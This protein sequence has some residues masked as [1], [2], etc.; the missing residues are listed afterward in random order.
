MSSSQSQP[1]TELQKIYSETEQRIFIQSISTTP[2]IHKEF[3]KTSGYFSRFIYNPVNASKFTGLSEILENLQNPSEMSEEAVLNLKYFLG[4]KKFNHKTPKANK[5]EL[6]QLEALSKVVYSKGFKLYNKVRPVHIKKTLLHIIRL[7]NNFKDIESETRI[8]ACILQ[9][10]SVSKDSNMGEFIKSLIDCTS[11]QYVVGSYSRVYKLTEI[12]SELWNATR[13]SAREFCETLELVPPMI[14]SKDVL[15]VN[16]SILELISRIIPLHKIPLMSRN[17]KNLEIVYIDNS[18]KTTAFNREYTFFTGLKKQHKE[19]FGQKEATD[20]SKHS[21]R[22]IW[23]L[24]NK[25]LEIKNGRIVAIPDTSKK[26]TYQEVQKFL[27]DSCYADRLSTVFQ[28]SGML[29]IKL[30]N[31]KKATQA[32]SMG[33]R[34]STFKSLLKVG[35]CGILKGKI[36][37]ELESTELGKLYK[38]LKSLSENAAK[39]SNTPEI[40]KITGTKKQLKLHRVAYL[41]SYFEN[42]FRKIASRVVES[43]YGYTPV[44]CHDAIF[45]PLGIDLARAHKDTIQAVYTKVTGINIFIK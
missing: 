7:L 14:R 30:D 26:E 16:I 24:R 9:R 10:M 15:S 36:N 22:V 2:K 41:C 28:S 29:N 35:A 19:W 18:V 34:M 20:I 8:Y 11:R 17:S 1:T 21:V 44:Q 40:K 45:L 5:Y 42:T 27:F 23:E 31:I 4:A 39:I 13:I 32:A 37:K 33:C 3:L 38:G 25:V 43:V 6:A 12:G